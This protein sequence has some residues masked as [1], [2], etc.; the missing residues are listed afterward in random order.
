MIEL[1]EKVAR[2]PAWARQHIRQLETRSEPAI[3]EAARAR[4]A[5][6][7]REKV[8][9][10]LQDANSALIELL[11]YAGRA[12]LDWAAKVADVL[13]GYEIFKSSDQHESNQ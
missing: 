13:D 10:R 4:K 2:L 6:A 3:E 1:Q 5:L 8:V 12:G 9:K 11:S 7:E